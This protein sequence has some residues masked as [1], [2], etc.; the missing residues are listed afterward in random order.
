MKLA[1][2]KQEVYECWEDLSNFQD[3]LLQPEN[4]KSD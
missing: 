4:F 1:Q 2:L 3:A